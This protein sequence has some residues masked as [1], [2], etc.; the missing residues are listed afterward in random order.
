MPRRFLM[1]SEF[2]GRHAR[3]R[4]TYKAR[5]YSVTCAELGLPEHLWTELGSYQEA[6][7]WWEAKRREIDNPLEV[8]RERI[9]RRLKELEDGDDESTLAHKQFLAEVSPHVFAPPVVKKP[10]ITVGESLD[11]YYAVQLVNAEPS[12][13]VRLHSF[14]RDF[15]ALTLPSPDS[16]PGA[17]VLS[18]DMPLTVIDEGKVLQVYH[19]VDKVKGDGDADKDRTMGASKVRYF[20]M[21][22]A[23]VGYCA[24][25]SYI[26]SPMNIRSKRL[27]WKVDTK[28]KNM[29]DWD[30]VRDFLNKLPER[31][32]LYALLALNTGMN[33]TDIA[34]LE[35]GQIDLK[36]RTLRRKRVKTE[37]WEKVPTVLYSLWDET[38]R[39]L[40]Q[41][42]TTGAAYALLDRGGKPLYVESKNAGGK[43]KLY[44]KVK[45]QWR[46]TLGRSSE[47]PFTLK[48][49]RDFGS[50]LLQNSPFRTY[51]VSW[52]GHTPKQ[53]DEKNYSGEE[54]ARAA[55]K[56]MEEVIFHGLPIK[57]EYD[58]EE[59]PSQNKANGRPTSRRK[60]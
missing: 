18:A 38:V 19:Y 29:P 33:N 5:P 21:F 44:D 34:H 52:L 16:Q 22:R 25:M 60:K 11:Q 4:K 57:D 41:E 43:P 27:S 24:E 9:F 50:L 28:A 3:W 47:R 37:G 6:N 2:G 59:I 45:S 12:S 39:L 58:D 1:S 31:L 36:R 51:R 8:E 32:R 30:V 15:K 13:L 10:G 23:F 35:E 20:G 26:P 46:D 48:D 55:C 14:V 17:V 53:V 56:W 42:M 40:R 54:D 49:F 7:R